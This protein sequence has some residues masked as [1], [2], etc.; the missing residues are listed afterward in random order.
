MQIYLIIQMIKEV[1]LWRLKLFLENEI[2]KFMSLNI[3]NSMK[4]INQINRYSKLNLKYG[5]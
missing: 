3:L 4:E 5:F 2:I 1:Y